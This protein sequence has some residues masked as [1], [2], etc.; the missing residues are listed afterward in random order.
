MD[1][2]QDNQCVYTSKDIYQYSL[3]GDIDKLRIAL[4]SD[5]IDDCFSYRNHLGW[6]ALHAAVRY[7]NIDCI[8]E[9][10]DSGIDVNSIT[11]KEMLT[12]LHLSV[13]FST[14]ECIET[15]INRGANI[16]SKTVK[17]HTPLHICSILGRVESIEFLVLMGANIEAADIHGRRALHL[18]SI[19]CQYDAIRSLLERGADINSFDSD[20]KTS[21]HH[22]AYRAFSANDDNEMQQLSKKCLRLLLSRN[23]KIDDNEYYRVAMLQLKEIRN[24]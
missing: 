17:L 24:Y 1:Q 21:L 12:G 10:I 9:L 7:N 20:G 5:M 15:L 4:Q 16:E 8:N 23:A 13:K 6:N 11:E 19:Y 22:L 3:H 2:E 14:I 18:S